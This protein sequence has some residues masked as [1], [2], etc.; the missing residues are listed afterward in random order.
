MV[1]MSEQTSIDDDRPT[2]ENCGNVEDEENALIEVRIPL[3]GE[4]WML[5]DPCID[6]VKRFIETDD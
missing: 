1:T 5:C 3:T 4:Y 2:C 6:A